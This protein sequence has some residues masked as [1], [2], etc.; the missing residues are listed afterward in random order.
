MA[1]RSARRSGGGNEVERREVSSIAGCVARQERH[2]A[3]DRVRANIEVRHWRPLG[4]ASLPVRKEGLPSEEPGLVREGLAC[5]VDERCVGVFDPS[6]LHA[7][8]GEY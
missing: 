5:E 3:N 7:D 8:L 4:S 2:A 1:S 6:E